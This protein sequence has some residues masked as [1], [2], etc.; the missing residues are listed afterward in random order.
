MAANL[1]SMISLLSSLRV[2]QGVNPV[3]VKLPPPPAL[4]GALAPNNFLTKIRSHARSAISGPESMV[5]VNRYIYTGLKDGWVVE[6]QPSGQVRKILRMSIRSCGQPGAGEDSC[7]RPLG[8]RADAQ[9]YLVVADAY[10]GIFRVHPRTGQFRQLV[11]GRNL[12][13]NGRPVRFINDL[14]VAKDGTIYF[15]SSST[16]W[17][18]SQILNIKFEGETSGRV[19]VYYPREV[20]ASRRVQEL[21][22]NLHYPN[23]LQLSPDESFLLIGEGGRC[24]IHRA[25]IGRGSRKF[26]TIDTFADNLPGNVDNVRLSPRGTYWVGLSRARHAR[27]PSVMDTYGERPEIRRKLISLVSNNMVFDDPSFGIVVELNPEG[28]I[29]RSLQDPTGSTY[30]SISE[31]EEEKG[32][33]FIASKSKDF[34]GVIDLS[35]LPPPPVSGGGE[36]SGV[37]PLPSTTDTNLQQLLSGVSQRLRHLDR[38]QIRGIVLTLVRHLYQSRLKTKETVQQVI[39]LRKELDLLRQQMAGGEGAGGTQYPAGGLTT[40]SSSSSSSSSASENLPDW[41]VGPDG[42]FPTTTSFPETTTTTIITT[43]T[44]PSSTTVAG[45]GGAVVGPPYMGGS[46]GLTGTVD[47]GVPGGAGS[48]SGTTAAAAAAG[49]GGEAGS[50]GMVGQTTTTQPAGASA[51]GG[52]TTITTSTTTTTTTQAGAASTAGET[53]ASA[54]F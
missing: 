14:A 1:T 26:G 32:L 11:D 9:G 21:V 5:V 28:Q 19:L 10:N 37:D 38:T 15:T 49:G 22:A 8:V 25:W 7:G 33:L 13:V 34:I 35:K 4:E 16:K 3:T 50:G 2:P 44:T 36:E 52:E 53:T 23:G 51:Q 24:K 30:T 42:G 31:V 48:S 6:I 27:L 18:P 47:G 41:P 46:S 29:V 40:P 43:T 39:R 20:L 45:G 17:R 54:I 12:K